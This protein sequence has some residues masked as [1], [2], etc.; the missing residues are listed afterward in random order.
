MTCWYTTTT[1]FAGEILSQTQHVHN[2]MAEND[3]IF[4]YQYI[5]IN[6][7]H[8]WSG[9]WRLEGKKFKNL[10]WWMGSTWISSD[11]QKNF[12]PKHFC[13]SDEIHVDPIHHNKF[14]NFLPS[15]LHPPDQRWAI[16]IAIYWYQKISSFSAILLCTCCVWDKISPANIVVVV[17]QQVI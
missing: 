2:N 16:F 14:L 9:G 12:G 11:W 5:A 17:Y 4:W 7:A 10:L 1:I 13:Q 3:D 8:L 15:S 6:I